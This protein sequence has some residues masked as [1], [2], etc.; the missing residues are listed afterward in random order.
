MP[1]IRVKV[2]EVEPCTTVT[3]E[4]MLATALLELDRE[5]MT[6]PELAASV[7]V[8]VP[9]PVRPLIIVLGLTETPLRAAGSGSSVIP[10]A[11][12][13]LT[14]DAV[15]VTEVAV[16]TLPALTEKVVDVDPCGT[17]TFDGTVATAGDALIA[18]AAPPLGAAAVS[19]TVHVEPV[20]GLTEVGVQARLLKAAVREIVTVPPAAE[21]ATAAPFGSAEIPLVSWTAEELAVVELASVRVTEATTLEGIDELF[22]P[23]TM[24]VAVPVEF[25]QESVFFVSAAPE[26]KVA[27]VKSVVE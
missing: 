26:A 2:A 17:V 3:L 4:G 12:L 14:Y 27:D 16:L 11:V 5:T 25:A 22:R 20:E 15:K 7:N 13:L 8:T 6:P 19:V 1:A 24:Q 18:T 21:V 23:Q 9:V 10:K